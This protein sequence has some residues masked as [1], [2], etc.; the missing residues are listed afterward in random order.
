MKYLMATIIVF[1][2]SAGEVAGTTRMLDFTIHKLIA[3]RPGN[4]LLVIGGIQ[5]DE[6]GGFNAASLLA[7]HYHIKKG[8]VW[9]VPNLNFISIIHRN[10][11]IYGDLNRKF[12]VI[13]VNDPE[14]T[15]IK[16]IKS[17]ILDDQ[18]DLILNLHDGSGFYRP[19]YIDKLHNPKRWG[20]SLIIDQQRV[21]SKNFGNLQ[22]IADQVVS[23]V[24]RHL[25]DESHTFHVK[26]TRTRDGDTEMAKT[27]TYFAA[28]HLKPAFGLE[29]SKSFRT[30]KRAYYHIQAVEAFMNIL[31]IE[32]E[33]KFRL[34]TNG[35]KD[36]IDKNLEV[37]FYNHRIFLDVNNA[38]RQINYMPLKK[39]ADIEFVPSN[40]LIAIVNFGENYGVYHGNRKIT[41][42]HPQYFEYDSSIEE[43][44]LVVDGNEKKA[45]FGAMVNVGKS[46]LVTPQRGYRVNVI[47]FHKPGLTNESGIP[48]V[49]ND[50]RKKFSIDKNGWIFRVEVYK[51]ERFAGMV[52][53]NFDLSSKA[54]QS[55]SSNR[56]TAI[57][58]AQYR[59]KPVKLPKNKPAKTYNSR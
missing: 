45:R 58:M 32:Y 3:D 52:L 44:T 31:G 34:S 5:G 14:F 43:I 33:R 2:L 24:N 40:P 25:F 36:A 13:S 15:A 55:Q 49:R 46:F 57:R 23:R 51:K 29:A 6:P 19:T 30:H 38:R 56:R 54:I 37:A 11:G 53:V 59:Q 22:E 50:I 47:G 1:L 8:N 26:N 39:N 28:R 7:T 4:T 42:L 48:I 10:R 18:V 17:L 21:Q 41:R 12:A 16:K 27:L 35:I 9:V 20:Q